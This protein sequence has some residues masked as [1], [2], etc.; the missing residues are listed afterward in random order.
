LIKL[1]FDLF[2]LIGGV[3]IAWTFYQDGSVWLIGELGI[4][5]PYATF[6]SFGV[7][8]GVA[9]LGFTFLGSI[10]SKASNPTVVGPLNRL[11]G[12]FFGAIKG[13]CYLLPVLIPLA[14]ADF[15]MYAESE[16]A[17]PMSDLVTNRFVG[18]K[19]EKK[20]L[21]DPSIKRVQQAL[22]T[23]DTTEVGDLLKTLQ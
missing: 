6:I 18:L 1:I 9:Y 19:L 12:L 10:V 2:A 3:W 13:F 23:G 22:E 20:V 4:R 15:P 8:W 21:E 16:I 14:H 11:G 5:E 7:V 17:K